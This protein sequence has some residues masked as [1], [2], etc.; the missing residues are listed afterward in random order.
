MSY[1]G[2]LGSSIPRYCK[3]DD[4][5]DA[6]GGADD[7]ASEREATNEHHHPL[8]RRSLALRRGRDATADDSV[9]RGSTT[10]FH[11]GHL[12]VVSR[13]MMPSGVAALGEESLML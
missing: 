3:G 6:A 13:P 1:E 7:V 4:V 8:L 5:P 10:C 2:H 12:L 11:R 9:G